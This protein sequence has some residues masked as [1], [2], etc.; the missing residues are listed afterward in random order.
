[1]QILKRST[2]ATPFRSVFSRFSILP[3]RL[4]ELIAIHP[5]IFAI[6]AGV[7]G[8]GVLAFYLVILPPGMAV[9]P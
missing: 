6:L 1:M 2:M 8:A 3:S 9:Y 7:M 4:L 5:G